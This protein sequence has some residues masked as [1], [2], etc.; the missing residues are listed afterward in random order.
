MKITVVD[1][2][3]AAGVSTATVSNALNGTG[4]ASAQTRQR[5]RDVAAALGYR[6]NVAGRT[7][8]TGRT[9][10]LALAVTTFGDQRWNFTGIA[11]Y[12]QVVAAAT[13]AAHA[14]GYALM[15]LPANL[16]ADGWQALAADGVV[17]L[18]SPEA[19]PAVEVLHA[20]GIPIAFD[21]RPH[22]LGPRDSWVDNDH[23][24]ITENVLDHLAAMGARRVGL[25]TADTADHYTRTC[26]EAYQQR[27]RA[28]LV[29]LFD[30]SD[31]TGRNAAERLLRAGP[32]AVY[33][34][35]D[36]CGRAVLAAAADLGLRVPEDVL[37]VTASE[38]P[39]YA[40]TSPAVSTVSLRPADTI[41][42]AVEALVGVLAGGS[43]SV[44]SDLPAELTV[45]ASS[46]HAS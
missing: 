40:A 15:V 25:L 22:V 14:H 2:A 41:T 31:L 6:P 26:I 37:V 38:D 7:L 45:R 29:E 1:V 30:T 33:G 32:D 24:A 23:A 34:L 42:A 35:V 43:P 28:P 8:R 19:D 18:D 39:G 20:R 4:R 44:R 12:A 11:Y 46:R 17:L 21:G 27:V 13:T 5:V 10:V 3:Q 16:D 9:G 36:P